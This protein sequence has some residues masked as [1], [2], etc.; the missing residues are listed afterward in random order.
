MS[1]PLGCDPNE[2]R[3]IDIDDCGTVLLG[4]LPRGRFLDLLARG[5][6]ITKDV[7]GEDERASMR[8]VLR[9]RREILGY[10]RDIVRWICKGWKI[11]GLAEPVFVDAEFYD[12]IEM[13]TFKVL[14]PETLD[15][16]EARNWMDPIAHACVEFWTLSE[17]EKKH[18]KLSLVQTQNGSAA[19]VAVSSQG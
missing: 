18:S 11:E 15:L 14:S 9:R 2:T 17:E 12:G 7:E 10:H 1:R 13:R 8:S 4:W 5:T 19:D 16:I 6:E 3:E